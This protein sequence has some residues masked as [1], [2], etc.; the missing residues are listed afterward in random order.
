MPSSSN[1]SGEELRFIV[2]ME[3]GVPVEVIDWATWVA[4]PYV[5]RPLNSHFVIAKDHMD[6]YLK[7]T[8]GELPGLGA[9]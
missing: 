1:T 7:A 4:I 5:E 9:K 2:L 3:D 8:R 6:A